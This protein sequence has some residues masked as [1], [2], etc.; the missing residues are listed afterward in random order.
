MTKE[1][2]LLFIFSFSILLM[3][4][5]VAGG[6]FSRSLA[7]LSDAGHMLTD[8]LA[9]LLSYLA[10]HWSRKPAT[11]KRT[12]GYHRTEILVSL[13]NGLTLLAV[14]IYIFY[15]AVHR[16]LYP[17]QIKVGIL[18]IVATIGLLGNMIGM[19]MLHSESH[20]S[21]NI[22]GAFFHLLGDTLSSLG[23]IAGAF[24]IHFTGWNIV[25]SLI[26]ILIGGIVL[27]GAIDLVLESG[28]V[29]L[30]ATPR[31]INLQELR[32]EVEKISG[33]REFHEV[34]IWTITSGRRALSGHILVDDISTSQSQKILCEVRELLAAHFNI[35]HTTL[36]TEC[37]G[38]SGNI[39]EFASGEIQPAK[40]H[41]H[42][43]F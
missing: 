14:S 1:N 23:V 41:H 32:S 34:H 4:I 19:F 8:A 38:C 17:E 43:E 6:F 25:D 20:E 33:V 31:D 11:E 13:I 24:I 42:H 26:S 36:E 29:L 12:Y 2:K 22:R 28:E 39:C 9:I 3:L 15:E 37:E 21:L 7:L 18:L 30:E 16:F 40:E 27:R 35:T 10:V 5:E